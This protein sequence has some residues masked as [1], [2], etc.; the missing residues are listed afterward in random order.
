MRPSSCH[1]DV[2]KRKSEE[3]HSLESL[4]YLD[5]DVFESEKKQRF[6]CESM[7]KSVWSSF[8][9]LIGIISS[10]LGRVISVNYGKPFHVHNQRMLRS[11][12]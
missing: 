11:V 3:S 9:Q 2:G 10:I 7:S 5:H 12:P 1:D 8:I 4:F 6:R